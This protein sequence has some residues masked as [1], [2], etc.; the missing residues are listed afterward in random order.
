M[1]VRA[2]LTIAAIAALTSVGHAQQAQP[3]AGQSFRECRNCPEMVVVPDGSFMMGSPADEPERREN[4]PQRR[5]TIPRP[6]AISR[7]EV[8]WDQW[9][10]CVRDRWC[11]GPGVELALR[12]NA[13]GTPNKAFTD[14]GRGTRPVIGV[15]W[16]DAQHF[17]GWLNW[18][19]GGDD[20]YRL[21]SEA[22]WEYACGAGTDSQWCCGTADRLPRFA[23]YSENSQD[24]PHPVGTRE[25]NQLGLFD[26][27]GNVWEWCQDDYAA[28]FYA[29]SPVHA[30]V[31]D[32]PARPAEAT[33]QTHK[34]ARGGGFYALDEMCRTRFRLH[35]PARYSAL[36]LGFRIVASERA[37]AE[38]GAQAREGG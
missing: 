12:T 30:P 1:P 16:F 2:L 20:V 22:E 3:T 4:E 35:D 18:K 32:D 8:T 19:A 26:L 31:N 28:D 23:W 13:D 24:R 14:W 11:D 6:F 21:P 34:V 9:E 5:V 38:T 15:S 37:G 17:V 27:H 7:T 33:G 10:A 36:D 29:R 25:P